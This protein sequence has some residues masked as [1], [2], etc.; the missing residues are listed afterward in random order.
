MDAPWQ[1]EIYHRPRWST[2]NCYVDSCWG[3]KLW[4]L[5][6][7]LQTWKLPCKKKSRCTKSKYNADLFEKNMSNFRNTWWATEE[8]LG[9]FK[10]KHDFPDHF[11]VDG[12]LL[13]EPQFIANCFNRVFSSVGH[14]LNEK[15]SYNGSNFVSSFLKRYVSSCFHFECVDS[16][17]V[18]KYIDDL[19]S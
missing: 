16:T 6:G 12:K 15:I 1:I 5:E 8:I 9:R 14:A 13:R 3:F 4:I 7:N 11:T 18:M 2:Q 19:A 17:A 10:N